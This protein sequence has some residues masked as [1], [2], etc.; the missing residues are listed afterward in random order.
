M[1]LPASEQL[2]LLS[3]F[4][5]IKAQK[6]RYY[7]DKNFTGRVVSPPP[8]SPDGSSGL[9]PNTPDVWGSTMRP[10]DDRLYSADEKTTATSNPSED[11]GGKEQKPELD[12]ATL[13][14][15]VPENEIKGKEIG[16]DD[17]LTTSIKLGEFVRV[18]SQLARA[19]DLT[20]STE[21]DLGM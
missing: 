15:S 21:I 18:P 6:V 8:L 20:R 16:D 9:S 12:I 11:A 13:V 10:V 14:A 3:G 7:A 17:D 2:I 4:S 1:Q 19:H 5:P